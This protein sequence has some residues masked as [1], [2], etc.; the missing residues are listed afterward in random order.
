MIGSGPV[1]LDRDPPPD[2]VV[3][4]DIS[5]DSIGRPGIFRQ[6]GVA[7]VW[8]HDGERASFLVLAAEGYQPSATS[9]CFPLLSADRLTELLAERA[10]S[11][12]PTWLRAVRAWASQ[13]RTAA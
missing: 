8:C 2:V 3:E 9:R 7:E 11:T 4:I 12:L 6:F 13:A 10:A 1:D 5:R